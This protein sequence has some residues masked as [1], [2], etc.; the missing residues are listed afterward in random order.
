MMAGGERNRI[1][2][3]RHGL[4]AYWRQNLVGA[5]EL[6]QTGGGLRLINRQPAT[7]RYSNAQLDDY[8]PAERLALPWQPP[9][10]MQLRARFSHQAGDLRGTAGFGFWNYPLTL[11]DQRLALPRLPRAIW[12]FCCAPPGNMQ[13]DLLCP[14]Q[15]W[16]AATIDSNRPAALALTPLAPLAVPLMRVPLLYRALWPIAQQAA[17]IREAPVTTDMRD[18]H[19]YTIEW[20]ERHSRFLVDEQV[21]LEQAL[22]PRGPMCFVIWIDNQFLELTPQGRFR[23]GLTSNAADQWLE[24]ERWSVDALTR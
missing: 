8:R 11:F 19:T 24:V 7:D 17:A 5:G 13:F 12:F 21:I 2:D 23:W 9:L 18:R 6:K 22:S 20:G 4:S 14:G 1:E 16:K 15:S 3:F 10:R